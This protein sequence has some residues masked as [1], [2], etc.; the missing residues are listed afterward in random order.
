MTV[1]GSVFPYTDDHSKW[2]LALDTTSNYVCV[3]GI[4]RMQSQRQ[5]GGGTL[6]FQN[7]NL[8]SALLSCIATQ[9]PCSNKSLQ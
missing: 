6:C 4:N 1:G 3:G 2:G 7:A 8:H 9:D 5:R